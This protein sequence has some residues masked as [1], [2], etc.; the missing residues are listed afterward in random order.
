MVTEWRGGV[1]GVGESGIKPAIEATGGLPPDEEVP[2]EPRSEKSFRR[3]GARGGDTKEKRGRYGGAFGEVERIPRGQGGGRGVQAKVSNPAEEGASGLLWTGDGQ[4]ERAGEEHRFGI[5]REVRGSRPRLKQ[6]PGESGEKLLGVQV[7]VEFDR[8]TR[9]SAF[10]EEP[11]LVPYRWGELEPV[12]VRFPDEVQGLQGQLPPPGGRENLYA[13]LLQPLHPWELKGSLPPLKRL[14]ARR[15]GGGSGGQ[16][17]FQRDLPSGRQASPFEG[18]TDLPPGERPMTS[19]PHAE[20][21]CPGGPRAIEA[22][23]EIEPEEGCGRRVREIDLSNDPPNLLRRGQRQFDREARAALQ[24][25]Q[26]RGCLWSGDGNDQG[27]PLKGQWEDS[28]GQRPFGRYKGHRLRIDGLSVREDEGEPGRGGE[29][30]FTLAGGR[31]VRR[32]LPHRRLPSTRI[33]PSEVD[34]YPS[35]QKG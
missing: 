30:E 19:D 22:S 8:K 33:T 15:E 31:G 4:R 12:G 17:P 29:F 35:T 16:S 13:D 34:P 24:L 20:P 7:C 1:G 5:I 10:G 9:Q 28:M 23:V 27:T 26:R 18:P 2:A 11:D 6:I 3:K 25:G 14:G 32:R 21:A